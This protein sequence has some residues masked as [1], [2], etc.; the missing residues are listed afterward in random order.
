MYCFAFAPIFYFVLFS[1]VLLSLLWFSFPLRAGVVYFPQQFSCMNN[2]NRTLYGFLHF[3]T[4]SLLDYYNSKFICIIRNKIYCHR[5][6]LFSEG[7]WTWRSFWRSTK[8]ATEHNTHRLTSFVVM[9]VKQVL[10]VEQRA[11]SSGWN[12]IHMKFKYV[13]NY[14]WKTGVVWDKHF[15]MRSCSKLCCNWSGCDEVFTQA[16]C[17]A[18]SI[19]ICKV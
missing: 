6:I 3:Q 1:L 7:S 8:Q 2:D 12:L 19:W 5:R 18:S 14:S 13:I 16:E 4:L 17:T 11:L 9:Q 10:K 15:S